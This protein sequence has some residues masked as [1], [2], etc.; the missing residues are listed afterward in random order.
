MWRYKTL[1]TNNQ[2]DIN[3]MLD[4][5]WFIDSVTAQHVATGSSVS[6]IGKFLV[7]FKK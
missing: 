5:G 7:V 6:I 4:D 3:A 1:I 2:D